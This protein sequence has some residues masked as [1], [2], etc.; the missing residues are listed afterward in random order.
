MPFNVLK[1][2]LLVFSQK[3][4]SID[5]KHKILLDGKVMLPNNSVKYLGVIVDNQ[6]NWSE[7]VKKLYNRLSRAIGI[8]SK[9]RYNLPLN[10]LR[11]VYHSIFNSLLLYA[12]QVWGVNSQTI[13]TKIQSLQ[14]RAIRK[15]TFS[16]SDC[17]VDKLYKDLKLLKFTDIV[18]VQNCIFMNRVENNQLPD[19]FQ[20]K[21]KHRRNIHNYNTRASKKG[22]IE[23]PTVST[24]KYGTLSTTFQCISDWNKFIKAF[25][26]LNVK[27][28]H[29]NEIRKLLLSSIVTKY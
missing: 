11:M 17:N 13:K 8:L 26:H 4:E 19:C 1:S 27:S 12:C 29:T 16:K 2:A 15:I 21:F 25:S 23:I 10:T 20:D 3:N 14:D 18:Y 6:L 28:L 22:Q 24:H 7:H 5:P 9:L